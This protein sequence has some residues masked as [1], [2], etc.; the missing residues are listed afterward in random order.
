[1]ST[2]NAHSI[3]RS[4]KI[5]TI[6][7]GDCRINPRA[8]R[9]LSTRHVAEIQKVIDADIDK[10]GTLTVSYR[11]NYYWI[12]DGQHRFAALKGLLG[13]GW[14]DWEITAWCYFDKTEDEEAELF[15]SFNS[16]KPVAKF[17]DFR[18]SVEAGRPE[19]VDIDRIVRSQQLRI[20][21]GKAPNTV[22][23][24]TALRSIYDDGGP[25]L[26]RKTLCTIRDAWGGVGFDAAMMRGL[27][28]F[29]QRFDGRYDEDKLISKLSRVQAGP[30][31]VGAA[32][33]VEKEAANCSAVEAH[34]SAITAIYNKGLKGP[35]SLGKW[36]KT[37][38]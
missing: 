24:V 18:V 7:M 31:G 6:R 36:W 32:A 9:Q 37:A 33:F 5:R 19:E 30:K 35:R 16:A 23:A 8:Q 29:I 34:A 10:I 14:E 4:A 1:M 22:G 12:I 21:Q 2:S 26:L 38:A 15:L 20:A 27:A 25:A 3:S 11:D 17:D 13:D 28:K